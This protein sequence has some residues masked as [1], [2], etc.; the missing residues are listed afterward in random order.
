MN[1][2]GSYL[3]TGLLSLNASGHLH[4]ANSKPRLAA[5]PRT[6]GWMNEQL[7]LIEAAASVCQTFLSFG[8]GNGSSRC[9]PQN[10]SVR[11]MSEGDSRRDAA[12]TWPNMAARLEN[13]RQVNRL[14][15]KQNEQLY[16]PIKTAFFPTSGVF[17]SFYETLAV[18]FVSDV[19]FL[20]SFTVP[21]LE[22]QQVWLSKVLP[23]K[24]GAGQNIFF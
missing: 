5:A 9:A 6:D 8:F 13:S 3:F 22:N 4:S 2:A 14:S 23:F 12:S 15:Y 18:I 24:L 10:V 1:W 16:C 11:A 20:F 21:S 17:C 19:F 7:V